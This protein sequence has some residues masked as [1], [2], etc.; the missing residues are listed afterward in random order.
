LRGR[1]TTRHSC[2]TTRARGLLEQPLP[3][4][5]RP[6]LWT[7]MTGAPTLE[8]KYR[9]LTGYVLK[10]DQIDPLLKMLWRFDAVQGVRKLSSLL[11]RPRRIVNDL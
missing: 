4:P 3:T 5:A 7:A 2:Y 6:M 11:R 1:E 9:W 10:K 8:Q